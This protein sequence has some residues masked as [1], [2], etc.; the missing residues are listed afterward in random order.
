MG[1]E[2]FIV[3]IGIRCRLGDFCKGSRVTGIVFVRIF[4]FLR[5]LGVVCFCRVRG[6]LGYVLLVVG[7][8]GFLF[9]RLLV[10]GKSTLFLG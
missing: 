10:F 7:R 9:Y 2:F 6:R 5:F 4:R 1:S 8:D 3:F